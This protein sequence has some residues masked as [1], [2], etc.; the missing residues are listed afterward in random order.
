MKR[1][2][3]RL[4]QHGSQWAYLRQ[5]NGVD[6]NVSWQPRD[7]YNRFPSYQLAVAAG[8]EW[9]E[10][11]NGRA[12]AAYVARLEAEGMTTSDAQGVADAEALA[13]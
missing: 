12:Y 9:S 2:G 4:Q 7:I 1:Y 3:F 13:C 6:L 10:Q 5:I 11:A 8:L